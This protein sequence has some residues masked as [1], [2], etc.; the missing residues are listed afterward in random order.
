LTDTSIKD[1][2]NLQQN[3]K[4]YTCSIY[5]V[6]VYGRKVLWGGLKAHGQVSS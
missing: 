1:K 6:I 4:K 2:F 5:D 3:G